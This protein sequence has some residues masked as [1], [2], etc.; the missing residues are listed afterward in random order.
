MNYVL[1]SKLMNKTNFS[2]SKY[3]IISELIISTKQVTASNF[4]VR[5]YL[6]AFAHVRIACHENYLQGGTKIT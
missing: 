4:I 2:H 6:T 1:Y 5:T 3:K